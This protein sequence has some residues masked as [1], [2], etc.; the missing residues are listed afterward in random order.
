MTPTRAITLFSIYLYFFNN[1]V[2]LV[3]TRCLLIF[4]LDFLVDFYY[5][6]M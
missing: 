5:K 1:V 6:S 4:E 3:K 2:I